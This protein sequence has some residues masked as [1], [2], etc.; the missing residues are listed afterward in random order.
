MFS[1][2]YSAAI[3]GIE[4]VP[5][6]VETD[7][8][9]GLPQFTM[10]GYVTAQVREA[11]DRVKTSL[12][13]AGISMHPRR[14]TINISPADIIKTGSRFD[15]PIAIG[16]LAADGKVPEEALEGL[17][18]VGELSLSGGVNSVTG[19]LP[20]AVQA[21]QMGIRALI[22]PEA[23][24]REARVV[25]GLNV[26]GIRSLEELIDY[27]RHGVVPEDDAETVDTALNEYDVDFCDIRGQAA[28]K[29]AAVVAA[30]GFH[31]LLLI[32]PPGSGKTMLAR[33][34]PTI[35]PP[36]TLEESLE[37]SQ[38]Y[39]I[40]GLLKPEKPFMGTRPF[41]APHHTM[42]A[43]AL[44]GGGRIPAPGELT[45]AHRGILFLDE[46]AEFGRSSIEILR[47][48]LEDREIVI[49]RT[50]GSF[51][52]PASFL[53][54]AAMNPCPCGYY[55]DMNRCHCTPRQI[56][57]YMNKISQPLLDRI[58]LCVE[59]PSMT[60]EELTG[61]G[62]RGEPSS[63]LREQVMRVHEIQKAR[64]A[65]TGLHFNSELP[66]GRL[67]EFCPMTD[68]AAALMEKAFRKMQLSARGYH[69]IIKVART[70]ADL[71]GESVIDVPSVSEA[72]C[73]RSIDRKY[74]RM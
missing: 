39:S 33:R 42:S 68:G 64:F 13:N 60:F 71:A 4:A 31:N 52:F 69:R 40:A 35:M 10:V 73:Y 30:A 70:I 66:A 5:V 19:V 48:P 22:V 17:M 54:L 6:Q 61:E 25:A 38:I 3:I 47:Q 28:V 26:I 74:W 20:I 67:E 32:G 50:A 63:V 27:L 21:R 43:Q 65:G 49:S 57:M 8:S 36:L 2:V 14:V 12:K 37:I 72:I 62:E 7:V 59:C 11:E 18:A 9:D 29:R 41:R 16:V 58:D 23:N 15:L 51:R 53:L 56:S 1:R 45:L 55:P 44:A 24:L 46:I 34:M